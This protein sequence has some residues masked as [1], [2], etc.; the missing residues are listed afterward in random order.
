MPGSGLS[1]ATVAAWAAIA[2]GVRRSVVRDGVDVTGGHGRA[3]EGTGAELEA[4]LRQT[5]PNS[6]RPP[7]GEGLD[8]PPPE[9]VAAEEDRPQAGRAGGA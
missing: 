4:R 5:P 6:S 9:T 8:K 1:T 7:S 2:R 3:V